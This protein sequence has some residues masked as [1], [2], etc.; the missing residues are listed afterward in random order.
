MK[1]ISIV[2]ED[3][4]IEFE[5]IRRKN[6]KNII[7]KILEDKKVVVSASKYTLLRSIKKFVLQQ[8]SWII[9]KLE[10]IQDIETLSLQSEVLYLGNK[11]QITELISDIKEENIQNQLD[12]FYKNEAKK[13]IVKMVENYSKEM[14]LFPNKVGFRKTKT[15]W[16]SCSG[17]NNLS[18]NTQLMK[19]DK[20]VIEYV[21]V[22]ELA[23]IKHKNHSSAFWGLVE[24]YLSNFKETRKKLTNI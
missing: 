20:T 2:Y 17:K 16:G 15:R 1:K 19:F 12:L 9:E 21:V 6:Q 10:N 18:F 4:T 8:A 11:Y 3:K 7:L 23:H 22:H 24:N 13:I 14:K 5:L